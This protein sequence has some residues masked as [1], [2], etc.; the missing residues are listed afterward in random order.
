MVRITNE[1][2]E[3]L[4]DCNSST[5]TA[6]AKLLLRLNEDSIS[7]DAV[8]DCSDRVCFIN[9]SSTE[10]GKLSYATQKRIEYYSWCDEEASNPTN[11]R[12]FKAKVGKTL[13]KIFTDDYIEA[14]Y[15]GF[16]T[17]F[18]EDVEKFVGLLKGDSFDK[19]KFRYAFNINQSYSYEETD[20]MAQDGEGTLGDS[21]MRHQEC[22]LDGYMYIYDSTNTPCRLLTYRDDDG[23]IS[24]RALI[25]S[26]DGQKYMDRIYESHDGIVDKFKA[27]AKSEGIISKL[28]QSYR[29]KMNWFNPRL[30][31]SFSKAII[32]E[33]DCFDEY[34]N[35]PYIDTF[36]YGF[37]DDDGISY[38]TNDRD[39]AYEK[40]K[41][42][43]FRVFESTGGDYNV[44]EGQA[45]VVIG[46]SYDE[47]REGICFTGDYWYLDEYTSANSE[48][49]KKLYDKYGACAISRSSGRF[50]SDMEYSFYKMSGYLYHASELLL[51]GFSGSLYPKSEGTILYDGKH[52]RASRF[53]IDHMGKVRIKEDCVKYIDL[54]GN[55]QYCLHGEERTVRDIFGLRRLMKDCFCVVGDKYIPTNNIQLTK[56]YRKQRELAINL[57]EKLEGLGNNIPKD[58]HI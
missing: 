37:V 16:T 43:S 4:R 36:T 22:I 45:V 14:F 13:R 58:L 31:E 30:G 55:P 51:C 15:E 52:C 57:Q 5:P 28:R 3:F 50:S 23:L 10:V 20:Y 9:K 38:L 21:C 25:W 11:E 12:R 49:F 41:V 56:L 42:T 19:S 33:V 47:N 39:Y 1:F 29:D 32:V 26:I 8:R 18:N 40:F 27:Y 7:Q 2:A 6:T 46:N 35:Y 34:S 53:V 24:G 48:F 44:S 17:N 54:N